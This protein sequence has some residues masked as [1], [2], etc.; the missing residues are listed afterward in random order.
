MLGSV[1]ASN[2]LGETLP[3]VI[4]SPASIL[5]PF[6]T[7]SLA[8]YKVTCSLVSVSFLTY[9]LN[10]PPASSIL[11]TVPDISLIVAL[12]LGLRASN[13]S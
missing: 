4:L 10:L 11:D 13:N 1:T 8:P 6:S 12:P 3:S 7:L 2:S 5:S 9:T